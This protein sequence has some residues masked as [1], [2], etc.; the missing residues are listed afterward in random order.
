MKKPML[1]TLVAAGATTLLAGEFKAG[2]AR[3]DITPPLG[4]YMPGYYQARH[5]KE[6]LD[7]LSINCVAF[8]DGKKTALIMQFDTE[9][10]SDWTA[11]G[12]RD[13][14][15]KATGVDRNAI[16]LHASHTHDGGNLA[17]KVTQS[18]A[19]GVSVDPLTKLY[20][21]M[22]TTRAADAAVEAIR[23][24]KVAKLSYQRTEAKRISFGRR[25]LMKNGKVQ[26]N[27]GTNNPDI[28]KPA[29]PPPDESVQVLRIDREGGKPI[30]MIN[31][32]TH[33]DVVG[34]ETITADWPGLT[35][36]VFEAATLG[37]A[38]CI[39]INGTQ[40]DLNH[41]NVMPKPGELNGLKRDFDAVDRGYDH[42]WHMAN[43]L[44][45]AALSKWL[46][47]IPLEAGDIHVETMTVRVPAHK[48]KDTDEKNLAWAND[49]WALHEKA[50]KDGVAGTAK[51]YVT[52]KYGWADM[53][54]TTEV[55]RAGRIRRMANHPDYHDLPLYGFAIGKSVAFGGFPGEPF[56]D[57]GKAV[58][59]NSPFPLTILSCLT[60]GSRGY[61]PFSDAYVGGGYESATSPFG[62]TVADDLIK[63]EGELM[64]KLYK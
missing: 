12:M 49:V 30:C 32:Q 46:K 21:E 18:S 38:H 4:V 48:A 53:E 43:V 35:R 34:G 24:L 55:A 15:V 44:A 54:L 42:A 56:N 47:C 5:A 52:A 22:A 26:T 16:L 51:D 64:Q 9:A 25:Y 62:P 11:D 57:I 50:R 27:P 28:V 33:P 29:G 17:A 59:K 10:L 2:F 37:K 23:D 45:G 61:F 20:V 1:M 8:N 40:G 3:T 6:I 7:P 13:A 14:I 19:A 60:N 41:C 63:G 36:T 39:V 31:F 58:K